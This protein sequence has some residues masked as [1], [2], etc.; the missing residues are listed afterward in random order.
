MIWDV[1]AMKASQ[2]LQTAE[3]SR[4][5]LRNRGIPGARVNIGPQSVWWPG[6]VGLYSLKWNTGR[7]RQGGPGPPKWVKS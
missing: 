7:E 6:A 5:K 3:D 2:T 4:E 1:W